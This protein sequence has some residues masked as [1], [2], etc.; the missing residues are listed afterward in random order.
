LPDEPGLCLPAHRACNIS[1]SLDEEW[2][3]TVLALSNPLGGGNKERWD[4]S[5]RAIKRLEAAGLKAAIV[6][7]IV[8]LPGGAASLA[9]DPVRQTWV[10]AKIVKGLCWRQCE[11]LLGPETEWTVLRP[12]YD[13]VIACDDRPWLVEIPSQGDVS[14]RGSVLLAKGIGLPEKGL[15]SWLLMVHGVHPYL[16]TTLRRERFPPGAAGESHHCLRLAWP[17][18]NAPRPELR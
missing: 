14:Q 5:I 12:D 2:L 8:P 10:L 3:A 15:F 13:D 17:K 11:T 9:T 1:T 6:S 4:R 18:G 7:G 16:V